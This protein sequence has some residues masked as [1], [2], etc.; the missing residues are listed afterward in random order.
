MPYRPIP[1]QQ[2]DLHFGAGRTT[3]VIPRS[4]AISERLL[5]MIPG[6][7]M[8]LGVVLMVIGSYYAPTLMIA[9]ATGLAL[10]SAIRFTLAGIA[11]LYG[12]RLIR[13]WENT[14]W[15]AVYTRRAGHTS[16]VSDA[17][18][19]LVIIPNY[20]EDIAILRRTLDH[21]AG[22]NSA[23][24]S[25]TVVLAIEA[26]ERG[27]REKGT[28]LKTEYGSRFEHFFV[29]VHP[30]G[31]T[32]EMQCKSAN[33]AWAAR[34]AKQK[35]V[36]EL[37]YSI[38]HLLVTTMDSDTIW[39]PH[40]FESLTTLFATD[41]QRYTTYWQAPIRYHGNVWHITPIMRI[42]HA[43][44]SA[45]ELAYLAAPWWR[46]LPM[47]SYSMSLR[48]LHSAGYWDPD[49]I[50]DEW[51]MYIKSFFQ[52]GGNIHL[53]PVFLPFW[54]NAT[55]GSTFLHAIKE[56]YMQTRR[57][58]W[59]AKEIGYTV[60]Q[61]LERAP[62]LPRGS[63]KLLVRV[64][65]D[66]L[67]AGPGWIIMMLGAQLPVMFYPHVT[68]HGPGLLSLLLLQAA[69]LV[70]S[71]LTL[72]FWVIDIRLRPQSAITH[73]VRSRLKELA[74]LPLMAVATIVC[75]ALPVM[76]AQTRLLLGL[77]IEFRVTAKR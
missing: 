55:T 54:A 65:H 28:V 70:V 60:T 72:M 4:F 25:M 19:H 47:S 67:L 59:G 3:W 44:S 20:H 32:G 7:L 11:N 12:L 56:R 41:Q 26:S 16:L 62:L 13:Q 50:A 33:Q 18:H 34:W 5:D 39:H 24:R 6:G 8:W 27:A 76:H 69:A 21:L 53:C 63:V 40:Y 1:N 49:A 30:T 9:C 71:L 2:R 23:Q 31:I 52:R 45:W 75:V 77:P 73:R 14:D 57:H 51:H 10:Y 61:I 66:N 15:Q 58:A 22:Q 17:V 38:N 36:D 29:V 74:C 68:A 37:G 64:A 43:Y 48:L 42:L 35:L 46:A